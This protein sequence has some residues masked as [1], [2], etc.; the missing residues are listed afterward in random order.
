MDVQ[1]TLK[2]ALETALCVKHEMSAEDFGSACESLRKHLGDGRYEGLLND[3]A[4]C[5]AKG[6][7]FEFEEMQW[8]YELDNWAQCYMPARP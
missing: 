6:M 8:M 4:I 3:I 2:R 7:F 1:D 5:N